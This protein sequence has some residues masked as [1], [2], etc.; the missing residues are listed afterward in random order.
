MNQ[1][2]QD[3]SKTRSRILGS[4]IR[5]LKTEGLSAASVSDIMARAG[6]TVGGFY[7]HFPSKDALTGEAV[8]NAVGERRRMFLDYFDDLKG[9]DR[10]CCAIDQYF[11][12]EHRDDPATGCPLSMAAQEA[13]RNQSISP[14]F[15][16]EFTRFADAMQNGRRRDG[17]PAPREAAIGTLALMV[18]GMILARAA[19]GHPISDEILAAAKSFGTAAVR[20]LA[21]AR[22]KRQIKRK[23]KRQNNQHKERS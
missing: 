20:D 1:R 2:Q 17:P 9:I 4:A 14:A 13:A 23:A 7:A 12:K 21:E 15:I 8:R 18:G 6:L 16:D 10:I 5:H 19:K 3:K 11:T 22:A